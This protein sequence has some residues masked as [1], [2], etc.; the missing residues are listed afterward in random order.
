VIDV[1]TGMTDA[2]LSRLMASVLLASPAMVMCGAGVPRRGHMCRWRVRPE[3]CVLLAFPASDVC[4]SLVWG[5]LGGVGYF[6][7]S[8]VLCYRERARRAHHLAGQGL[9]ACRYDSRC[10]YA[11]KVSW[12]YKN[13]T[14]YI[15]QR[16]S[17]RI[18]AP[19]PSTLQPDPVLAVMA[20]YSE[21][22][23]FLVDVIGYDDQSHFLGD[24][25]DTNEADDRASL[26]DLSEDEPSAGDNEQE[27]QRRQ[28][29]APAPDP[30]PVPVPEPEAV[31]VPHAGH[32]VDFG[33][34]DVLDYDGRDIPVPKESTDQKRQSS[35]L[36]VKWY[37]HVART[38][39]IPGSVSYPHVVTLDANESI[40][41]KP[42]TVWESY[43]GFERESER[44]H[45]CLARFPRRTFWDR[46]TRLM[47]CRTNMTVKRV[48]I[49]GGPRT[50]C[51]MLPSLL[52]VQEQLRCYFGDPTMSFQTGGDC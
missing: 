17:K 21:Q 32:L 42:Y 44:H 51:L 34:R 20:E 38:G 9:Q 19:K 5:R 41:F 33:T 10:T 39:A 46:L 26:A 16:A 8:I 4:V 12:P 18:K 43:K 36:V 24:V 13:P 23:H 45:G 52:D 37:D 25:S 29:P 47:R 15:M 31:V 40:P 48:P 28:A 22:S 11:S 49:T 30:E 35:D 3:T 1:L 50:N 14:T 6:R 7:S 27:Q 2:P